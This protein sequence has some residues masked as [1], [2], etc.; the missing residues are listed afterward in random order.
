ML[1]VESQG[2]SWNALLDQLKE[3]ESHKSD[4]ALAQSLKVTRGFI[5]AV[6]TGRKTISVELGE[7]IFLRLNREI[8]DKDLKLFTVA[9]FQGDYLQGSFLRESNI[10]R[11]GRDYRGNYSQDIN[12]TKIRA[13]GYCDLC[14]QLGPFTD[15]DGTPYL[16]ISHIA[17][18]AAGGMEDIS[19]L[20]ALCPNC[21]KKLKVLKLED[22]INYLKEKLQIK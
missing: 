19:N 17:P 2:N 21:N 5:S 1:G 11:A 9:R 4:A 13:N 12:L 14:G 3:R 10:E 7:K 8:S 18:L 16:E 20:A 22:D 6:R 15:L